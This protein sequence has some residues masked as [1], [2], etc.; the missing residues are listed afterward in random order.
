MS[1]QSE[2]PRAGWEKALN[3]MR[4]LFQILALLAGVASF[5]LAF[6]VI[7]L[8]QWSIWWGQWNGNTK[9]MTCGAFSGTRNTVCEGTWSEHLMWSG[10]LAFI[11]IM[12]LLA[13]WIIKNRFDCEKPRQ[14][15]YP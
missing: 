10:L 6:F 11:C 14:A 2:D 9:A 7:A 15:V 1:Y 5:V 4:I 12:L 8:D 3:L 13:V